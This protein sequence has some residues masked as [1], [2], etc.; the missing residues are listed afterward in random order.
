M[1]E[2]Q[3]FIG[4]DDQHEKR[5]IIDT[6]KALDIIA[7][8]LLDAGIEGCTFTQGKGLYRYSDGSI[9]Y[10]SSIIAMILDF[11]GNAGEAI[12][13]AAPTIKARLN[14]EAVALK[15]QEVES[16]LL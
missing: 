6:Q 5:Q 9:G 15:W 7:Q 13:Q 10:E 14:Q 12:K 8:A 2:Y 3:L 11:D 1:K 4:L 16:I